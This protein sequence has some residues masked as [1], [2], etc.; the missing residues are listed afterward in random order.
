M[1]YVS[2]MERFYIPTYN[3]PKEVSWGIVDFNYEKCTKC[4]MCAK[5]CYSSSI[6][7]ENNKP[8]MKTGKENMCIFCGCCS[9]ICPADAITMEKPLTSIGFYKPIGSGESK[10][11]RL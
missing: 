10:P 7:I 3:D 2:L 1:K 5:I 11:P 6:A 8:V 4:S 9:A